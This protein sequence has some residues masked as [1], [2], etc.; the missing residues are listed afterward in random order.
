[1]WNPNAARV[2]R[3]PTIGS[4]PSS[5]PTACPWNPSCESLGSWHGRTSSDSGQ[6]DA[7]ENE[8]SS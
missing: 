3:M 8:E 1:M 2:S 5:I 6:E 4:L 7:E